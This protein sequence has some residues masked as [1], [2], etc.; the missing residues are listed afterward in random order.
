VL[1]VV[2]LFYAAITVVPIIP[3]PAAMAAVTPNALA[4]AV[5]PSPIIAALAAAMP[6]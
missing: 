3:T 5:Y 1:F 2:P 6:A 4:A